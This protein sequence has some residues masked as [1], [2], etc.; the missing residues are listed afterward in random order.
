MQIQINR[1]AP[2]I[3]HAGCPFVPQAC[4]Y[5]HKPRVAVENFVE[6][7]WCQAYTAACTQCSLWGQLTFRLT[8]HGRR[9]QEY[10]NAVKSNCEI[11]GS[12]KLYDGYQILFYF[13]FFEARLWEVY[14]IR[15]IIIPWQWAQ[16]NV[17]NYKFHVSL[18]I[19]LKSHLQ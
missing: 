4:G 1:K 14:L 5:R 3:I 13:L 15:E 2:A 10:W 6:Q 16:L 9:N 12:F 18:N 19:T 11:V 7:H 17:L 8:V